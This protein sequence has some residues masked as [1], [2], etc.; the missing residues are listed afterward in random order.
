MIAATNVTKF[1][2]DHPAVRDLSFS[3]EAGE[4]AGFLGLN[5]AGKTTTLRMVSCQLVPTAGSIRVDGLDVLE[6]SHEIRQRIGVLPEEPPLYPEMTVRSFLLFAARVKGVSSKEA[7]R[8]VDEVEEKTRLREVRDQVIGT[9]SAG[10]RQRVGIAQAVVHGPSVIILDEPFTGL[11]PRQTREMREM[12]LA[13]RGGHTVLLSSHRLEQIERLCDRL[14]VL[15]Q[16]GQLAF[17]GTE[18]EFVSLATGTEIEIRASG[19]VEALS[20]ALASVDGIVDVQASSFAEGVARA[21][22]RVEPDR[23]SFARRRPASPERE[24]SP[25]VLT[26]GDVREALAAAVY[27]AGLGLRELRRSDTEIESVFVQ[28][29]RSG[30]AEREVEA[31]PPRPAPEDAGAE[32]E[33]GEEVVS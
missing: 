27:E 17:E 15:N 14:I 16:G 6:R 31:V 25:E 24:G 29:T 26:H 20:S 8:R 22:V 1:Y 18:R 9:L 13:L 2:G 4:I 11:D 7:A 28:L 5:G 10:F 21:A 23:T 30:G 33:G 3:V 32:S 19:T 12:I